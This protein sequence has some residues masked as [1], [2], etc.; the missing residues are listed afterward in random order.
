MTLIEDAVPEWADYLTLV[1]NRSAATVR[2]YT[3]D[4]RAA[5]E[6]ITTV[7]QLTLT[8][9]RAHLAAH[10]HLGKSTRARRV[11]AVKQ[12]V[13]WCERQGWVDHAVEMERL[14]VPKQDGG[15]AVPHAEEDALALCDTAKSTALPTQSEARSW[16]LVE[17]LYGCG[18]RIE[19]LVNLDLG[20]I[21]PG[22]LTL[23]VRSGKGDRDRVLPI[24][25]N[26]LAPI[27]ILMLV[28]QPSIPDDRALFLGDQG[29]RLSQR[30][31][32]RIYQ[33]ACT[34]ANITPLTPHAL[35]HSCATDMLN[36]GADIRVIAEHLG[37]ASLQTTQRYLH[38]ATAKLYETVMAAH[39]REKVAA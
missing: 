24:G 32:R 6:G 10:Q 37:H 22:G 21:D 8:H 28:R 36:H 1:K 33:Q 39:P 17:L 11:A 4:V 34:D 31:A 9:M 12:F 7:D 15:M 5:T 23:R 27:M 35:R 29:G 18:L 2:G 13:R 38:L 19:E 26:Q 30:Q 20:D 25:P 3:G 16:A 14:A